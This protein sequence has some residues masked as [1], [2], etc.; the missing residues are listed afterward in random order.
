LLR[1]SIYKNK[2]L[3]KYANAHCV[4]HG[5]FIK[6]ST[7]K[8]IGGFPTENM[9]EDL[10]LGYLIKSKGLHIYPLPQLELADSPKSVKSNWN[11]KFVWFW[12]PMKYFN[13]LRHVFKLRHS[14]KIA[15]LSPAIFFAIQ[16][17]I[18]ALAWLIS[19]PLVLI[20]L[21][22]PLFI[23]NLAII[24]LAYLSVIVYGPL[25]YYLVYKSFPKLFSYAGSC[26][27]D[28]GFL[29]LISVSLFSVPAIVFHSLPPIFSLIV[30]FKKNVFGSIIYKPKTD[31]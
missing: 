4:G 7:I 13:Y 23:N 24:S 2:F 21:I 9:T 6:T 3:K 1:Q 30:E 5:L 19:G 8:R 12:G 15:N 29:P 14:L 22:S 28:I 20:A 11:Q 17:F 25:Q 16:G 18:S 31:D 10:F 27:R 26:H